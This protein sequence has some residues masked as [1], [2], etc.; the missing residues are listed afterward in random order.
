M[1]FFGII[2]LEELTYD[3]CLHI[4]LY[5]YIYLNNP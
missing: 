1:S 3:D 2:P 5:I 4:Y